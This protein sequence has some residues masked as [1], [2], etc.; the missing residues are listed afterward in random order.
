M[1]CMSIG[2]ILGPGNEDY[3]VVLLRGVYPTY[4]S[5]PTTVQQQ[6]LQPINHTA[7]SD[8]FV[9]CYIK[10]FRA[11]NGAQGIREWQSRIGLIHLTNFKQTCLSQIFEYLCMYVCTVCMN[12]W[13]VEPQSD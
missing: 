3:N 9:L 13:R 11:Q 6:S 10:K 12:S 5:Q 4:N 8:P 2:R 7:C 1:K